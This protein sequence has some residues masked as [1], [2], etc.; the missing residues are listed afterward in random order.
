MAAGGQV[1]SARG[2]SVTFERW[3]QMVLA[4]DRLNLDISTGE[5]VLLLGHNG[6]GKTTLLK[7]IM[8]QIRIQHGEMKLFKGATSGA[9]LRPAYLVQQDPMKGTAPDLTVLEN[10]MIADNDDA[11]S[12]AK[13][14][15]RTEEYAALL[16]PVGLADRLNHRARDLSGGER[17]LISLLMARIAECPVVLLDEPFTAL[18]PGRAESCLLVVR[19]MH[20]SGRTIVQVSHNIQHAA[21]L[22]TRVVVLGSGRVVYDSA[23]G[24]R[25]LERM[26]DMWSSPAVE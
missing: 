9:G 10:L 21:E 25:D 19:E 16:E 2:V 23:G 22:G 7:C 15:R 12:G 26:R 20:A 24:E 17:Q 4:L 11:R 13:R 14:Q 5:W 18:D 1:L 8:Q 6:S 3:G